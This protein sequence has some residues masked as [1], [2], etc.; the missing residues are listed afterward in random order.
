M[1]SSLHYQ[2]FSKSSNVKPFYYTIKPF[3]ANVFKSFG[4]IAAGI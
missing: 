1:T 3:I 4:T 2:L